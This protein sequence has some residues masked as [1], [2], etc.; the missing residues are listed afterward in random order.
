MAYGEWLYG[1]AAHTRNAVCITLG[2]GVGG[3]LILEGKL[4]RGSQLAAASSEPHSGL[5]PRAG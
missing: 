3:A 5:E 1:S 2:T 4:Y